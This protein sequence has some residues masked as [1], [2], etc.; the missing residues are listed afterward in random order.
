MVVC[1]PIYTKETEC[2]DCRKC[3]RE[4]PVKAIKV[5]DGRASVM[6][7]FCILCGHCVIACPHG[8]KQVRD[9]LQKAR[10]LLSGSIKTIVS[11]DPSFVSEFPSVRTGQIIAGLK[12]LGFSNVSETAL[13]AEM[14]SDQVVKLLKK[15]QGSIF[16]SSACP[17][18][19]QYLRKYK[20]HYAGYVTGLLSPLLAHALML[21]R[22]HNA[23]NEQIG[24]VYIGPCISRKLEADTHPEL[25]DVALTFDDL[26]MWLAEAGIDLTSLTETADDIFVPRRSGDGALYPVV[27]G[28]IESILG[29]NNGNLPAQFISFSG[30]RRLEN[31]LQGLEDLQPEDN[32]F[33]ELSA[34]FGGCVNGP[35]SMTRAATVCKRYKVAHSAMPAKNDVAPDMD[36]SETYPSEPVPVPLYSDGQ[37]RW[38][39]RQVGKDTEKDELNCGG[40]GYDSCK[41]FARAF[42]SSK[43]EKTMCVSY[44]RS[45]A[46]KKADIL[47]RN[48]PSAVVIVDH[49]MKIVECNPNFTRL[50]GTSD[51]NGDEAYTLE[52]EQLEKVVP[53]SRLFE[54]V[55]RSGEDVIEKDL[56][57]RGRI[58]HGMIFNIERHSLVGALFEDI[59]TPALHREEIIKRARHVIQQNLMTVQKIAYL[60]GENAAE[61]EIMLNSIV[62]SFSAQ[63]TEDEDV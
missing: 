15:S 40:C 21:R 34:C 22:H 33:L 30:I 41:E 35:K 3:I 60:M 5:Q 16:I 32:L 50:F 20:P 10:Q 6:P 57:F 42:I 52:G 8:A 43:A 28:M 56:R 26:L 48:M 2:Q 61:S 36:I 25:V 49:Q 53:F 45:L 24:I 62:E 51:Q 1:P 59:T 13:G 29:H 14:V 27:G 47:I 9:D 4:C 18:V 12:A 37:I 7:D 23:L 46:Q 19:V 63:D 38:A 31:A 58:F 44:M 55:L 11:L 54:N 39:L 17:T